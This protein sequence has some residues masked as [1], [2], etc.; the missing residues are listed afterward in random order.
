MKKLFAKILSL[1]LAV[2]MST[3][4]LN[5]CGLVSVNEERDMAQIIATISID[6]SMKTDVKKRELQIQYVNQASYYVSYMGYTQKE[7]YELLLDEII[8]QE[9]LTQQSMLALTGAT[10]VL[11]NETGLFLQAKNVVD[12]ERTTKE[13]V[14]TLPNYL[15]ADMTTIL[16][17]DSYDKFL[18]DYE[19]TV[20]RFKVLYA[21][22]S[23]IDS[24]IDKEDE[25]HDHKF[26]NYVGSARATLPAVSEEEGNEYEL[27]YDEKLKVVDKESEFFKSHKNVND[28]ANLGLNL[29]LYDNKY[30]LVMA[31]YKKYI[32]KFEI[33][34]REDKKAVNKLLKDLKEYGFISATEAQGQPV[35]ADDFLALTY[36]KE[37]LNTQY[38]TSIIAKYE[39]ALTNQQEKTIDNNEELYNVYLNVFQSQK[40]IYKNDYTAYEAALENATEI[41]QV[42]Y[43]PNFGGKYGQIL[44]LLIGFNDA[45]NNVIKSAEEN[46]NLTDEQKLA[47]RNAM[48]ST[49][50]V[51]DKRDSWVDAGYGDY[52]ATTGKVTFKS[53]YCKTETLAQY[54]GK[55]YGAK[56]Y[57]EHDSYDNEVT[58]HYFES[59]KPSI[60]TFNEFLNGKSGEFVGVNSIMGFTSQDGKLQDVEDFNSLGTVLNEENLNKYRDLIYAFSTDDGSLSGGYGYLYSPKTSPTK[61]VTEFSNAA[62]YL[63]EKGVGSYKVVPTEY[64]Y[65]VMLCAR[66][67]EPNEEPITKST[68]IDDLSVENSLAYN[69]KEY[70]KARVVY[71]N[72]NKITTAFINANNIEPKVIKH[73]KT[74]ED[75]LQE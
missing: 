35:D 72:I 31:V 18:T 7:T 64:G 9:I 10:D 66:V 30:D 49:L 51:Q 63:I 13:K 1:A 14:L 47:V 59:V 68:F 48:L 57:V 6:D 41:S 67:I 38:E 19:Y 39:L 42:V 69:F 61:Y 43:H 8:K 54:I 34:S 25:E 24:Y 27:K 29:E 17:T 21:I 73:T 2:V 20:A 44:N 65:H 52:D 58:K 60:L 5:G 3:F 56:E 74:Y 22:R 37:N 71:D 75:L 26:E 40:A 55:V 46:K 15:G 16:K 33:T 12:S 53:Q 23:L 28:K 45:Q 36:F 32:E 62:K 50:T 4:V 70:Q 11:G